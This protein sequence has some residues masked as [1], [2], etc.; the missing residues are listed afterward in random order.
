MSRV[1]FSNIKNVYLRI[2]FFNVNNI[3]AVQLKLYNS[4]H[5]MNIKPMM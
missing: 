2:I 4:E 3:S 1:V 5:E